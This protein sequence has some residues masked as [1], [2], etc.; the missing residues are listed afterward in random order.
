MERSTQKVRL[1]NIFFMQAGSLLGLYLLDKA[2]TQ[3]HFFFG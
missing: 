3:F 1:E 2:G